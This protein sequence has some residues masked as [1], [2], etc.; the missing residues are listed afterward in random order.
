VEVLDAHRRGIH[1]TIVGLTDLV[2]DRGAKR[3][4]T[5]SNG[6]VRFQDVHEGT[7]RL[8]ISGS[9]IEDPRSILFVTP[10]SRGFQYWLPVTDGKPVKI[11]STPCDSCGG[12]GLGTIMAEPPLTTVV[13]AK[14][15]TDATTY[16]IPRR[17]ADLIS[18]EQKSLGAIF[19]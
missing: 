6:R 8:N 1:D 17:C 4:I 12:P 2:S 5:D 9:G 10:G 11:H 15:T 16:S 3:G 13:V 18:P 19:F 7:Y 14:G